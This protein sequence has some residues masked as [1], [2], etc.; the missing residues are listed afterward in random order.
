VIASV[1]IR[2][3]RGVSRELTLDLGRISLFSG[4]NG[5]GK[6]TVFDALDWCFFGSS[7]RLG[8][9]KESIR[10]LYDQRVEPHVAVALLHEGR[11]VVVERGLGGITLDGQRVSE[12]DLLYGFIKDP[13][14]FPPYVRDV[15]AR[16]RRL[17]YLPQAEIRELL[18]PQASTERESVFQSL[19]GV[20]DAVVVDASLRRLE[21]RLSSRR[22]N[23]DTRLAGIQEDIRQI[24]IDADVM[25]QHGAPERQVLLEQARVRLGHEASAMESLDGLLT[26]ARSAIESAK[27]QRTALED[28]KAFDAEQ[29]ER[30]A[31]LLAEIESRQRDVSALNER[32]TLSEQEL[33]RVSGLRIA[34][35]T[36]LRQAHDDLDGAT[37]DLEL[38]RQ[39]V[40]QADAEAE[41]RE[42]L[43]AQSKLYEAAQVAVSSAR[44]EG[45]AAAGA[46]ASATEAHSALL[47]ALDQAQA[48]AEAA[49]RLAAIEARQVNLDN[50]RG[51]VQKGFEQAEA[52]IGQLQLEVLSASV[53][54][55]EACRSYASHLPTVSLRDH[56]GGLL[57]ELTRLVDEL[58]LE[59]C[60]LCGCVYHDR[61]DLRSHLEEARV[62]YDREASHL[63]E[64]RRAVEDAQT[65]L[66]QA[67][68]QLRDAE[69]TAN[70]LREER[71]AL[72][73]EQ[74][75]LEAERQALEEQGAL[76][77]LSAEIQSLGVELRNKEHAASLAR[78]K[79]A[80][81]ERILADAEHKRR[82][83]AE[84]V[85]AVQEWLDSLL[86]EQ[87][88]AV[89]DFSPDDARNGVVVMEQR[90]RDA[91]ATM[92]RLEEE[93]ISTRS[94][95]M[96]AS[97]TLIQNQR[98]LA[99]L[100]GR[101]AAATEHLTSLEN[102]IES[103]WTSLAPAAKRDTQELVRELDH[104]RYREAELR[105]LEAGLDAA[106]AAQRQQETA[107]RL[108]TL[109]ASEA[110]VIAE[111]EELGRA[112]SRFRVISAAV[113]QQARDETN[114]AL[115]RHEGAI[116]ECLD[117]LYP[118]K[119]LDQVRLDFS[120]NNLLLTDRGLSRGV[121]PYYYASTGQMNVLA[122]AVFVGI[123]LRQSVCTLQL[124]LLDEPIQNLDDIH[125]LAFI[126]LIRRVAP[127]R[128]VII[129]TADNN[130]AEI[131]GRQ[132]R[133]TWA[134]ESSQYAHY[135][136]LDFDPVLGPRVERVAD[137]QFL[138]RAS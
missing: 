10:N 86:G 112:H 25:I 123:A 122:L 64:L 87:G 130:I 69:L 88:D 84:Q 51:E 5:L 108:Q 60:P 106:V 49:S 30:R 38:A 132:M 40:S 63:A 53:R 126:A 79:Q 118:H 55:D 19:L 134:S 56:L 104:I 21:E 94:V 2:G 78:Q 34:S 65:V 52:R 121:D 72:G 41:A 80:E 17:V 91:L 43:A 18:S 31:G 102:E 35:E 83:L 68:Q 117:A 46:S 44:Q 138:R 98:Q 128:Q 120:T 59:T 107:F 36:E 29:A 90:C 105:S 47:R 57:I 137:K 70:V 26:F 37:R 48:R 11:R 131:F 23:L 20:P 115:S 97:E 114:T 101:L 66:T 24:L 50:R 119:H 33:Q 103:R 133:S 93:I 109:R 39:R 6:T 4:R 71:E 99:E 95:E 85:A 15:P 67:E 27:R 45:V 129:S 14:I 77:E 110:T 54:H 116:Q 28:L 96:Q 111:I 136:W 3:F 7:W 16:V 100:R 22:Q 113:R 58:A 74:Q 92:Q 1:S 62:Q 125:F 13:D 81:A 42:A 127:S 75:R 9:T 76:K 73:P 135:E 8:D 61:D 12:R 82:A 89:P 32:L 124:L